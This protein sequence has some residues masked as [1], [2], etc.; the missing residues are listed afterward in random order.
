M[1]QRQ[2]GNVISIHLVGL[3]EQCQG[4]GEAKRHHGLEV[5]RQ[6]VYADY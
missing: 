4:H 3:G 1:G 5:D 2:T 6:L